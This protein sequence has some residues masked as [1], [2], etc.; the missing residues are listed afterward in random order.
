MQW[1]VYIGR[2]II[3]QRLTIQ[4][5]MLNL[6]LVV[7]ILINTRAMYNL[8]SQVQASNCIHF[9]ITFYQNV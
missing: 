3:W 1:L 2:V 7:R 9:C 5:C 4:Y 8:V 6:K